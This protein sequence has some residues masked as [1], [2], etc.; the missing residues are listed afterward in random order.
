MARLHL[1]LA[2]A[3]AYAAGLEAPSKRPTL[4]K[5]QWGL[6]TP[7]IAAFPSHALAVAT[8][9]DNEFKLVSLRGLLSKSHR[10]RLF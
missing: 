6:L 5:R 7:L 10:L 2:L 8:A 1:A 9:A 3:A 4:A